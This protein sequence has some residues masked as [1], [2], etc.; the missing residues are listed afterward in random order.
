M[1]DAEKAEIERLASALADPTPGRIA[2]RLNRHIST[3]TWYMLTRG[4]IERRP[5]HAAR[6]YLRRGKMVYPYSPEQDARL[7]ALL[8]AP[9][10]YSSPHARH[11]A[12]A[13]ALT[14]EFG[15][16]RDYHSVHVRANQL[17]AAPEDKDA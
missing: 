6:P 11:R 5:G 10:D 17:A 8:A 9:G 12:V 16:A 1:S 3:V 4:L 15:I 14:E 13:A 7:L 2:S